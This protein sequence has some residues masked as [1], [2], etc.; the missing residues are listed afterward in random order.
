MPKIA[1]VKT[2]KKYGKKTVTVERPRAPRYYPA[3]DIK[4]NWRRTAKKVKPTKIRKSITP[5]TVLILLAGRFRGQRVV[6]LR[7]LDSGLLLISGPFK[8]NGVPLRRVNQRYVIATSTRLDI[9]KVA[10]PEHINDAY[11]KK[12][13]AV[14]KEKTPDSFFVNEKTKKK[15]K[16]LPETRL[17]DQRVIDTQISAII[18][19][20]PNL[21]QYL[22]SKFTL[23]KGQ[24]PHDLKF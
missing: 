9:S 14:H 21:R 18:K 6:T 20:T 13:K 7:V 12:A 22:Q 19:T 16:A 17:A 24:F 5:G 11:F 23:S 10:I 3:D 4:K 15:K 1:T 8:V 2:E